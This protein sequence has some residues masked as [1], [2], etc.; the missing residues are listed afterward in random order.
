M[1]RKRGLKKLERKLLIT[2]NQPWTP[3]H[4]LL[5]HIKSSNSG[6]ISGVDGIVMKSRCTKVSPME[7]QTHDLPAIL[8]GNC[9]TR[10]TQIP[11]SFLFLAC[12][13]LRS[14]PHQFNTTQST[15]HGIQNYCLYSPSPCILVTNPH[16]ITT[17]EVIVLRNRRNGT[18]LTNIFLFFVLTFSP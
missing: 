10:R 3:I 13:P 14:F 4:G 1:I 15:T 16:A 18:L 11:F 5:A 9:H 12:F 6:P 17:I 8:E 2:S 7:K